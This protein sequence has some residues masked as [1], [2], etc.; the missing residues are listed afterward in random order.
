MTI[1]NFTGQRV[2]GDPFL[3]DK[4][5][6]IVSKQTFDLVFDD[7]DDLLGPPAP[8]DTVSLDGGN[9]FLTY[10]W[11]G[12]GEVRGSST[13]LAGFLRIDLGNGSFQTIALDMNADGD[14]IPDLSNGNTKLRPSDLDGTSTFPFPYPPAC[15]TPGTLIETDRGRVAVEDLAPGDLVQTLD[16]GLQPLRDLAIQDVP[17]R[18]NFAPVWFAAGVLGNTEPLLVSPQHRMHIAGWH[19]E[20]HFGEAEVLIPAKGLVNG[21]T[22]SRVPRDRVTYVHLLFDNH[23]IVNAA[24]CWSESYFVSEAKRDAL[25]GDNPT[26]AE[27]ARLFPDLVGTPPPSAVLARPQIKC[28][29]AGALR[30]ALTTAAAA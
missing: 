11:M 23:E 2:N 29:D 18:G 17:A 6:N 26:L 21:T 30:S 9:T 15:F 27:L 3:T 20:L 19:A 5:M 28:R 14:G 24:G 13:Q 10:Q 16:H 8:G 22:I 4:K 12:F 7:S 1:Y 25:A